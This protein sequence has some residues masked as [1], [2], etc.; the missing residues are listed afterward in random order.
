MIQAGVLLY[1]ATKDPLY[2]Q[3][4]RETAAGAY[5]YF[6]R[7][8]KTPQG[9]KLFYSNM[10]WFNVILLRGLIALYEVDKTDTYIQT[11]KENALYAWEYTRDENGL[12]GNDWTG[13]KNGKYKWLLDNACMIELYACMSEF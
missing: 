10:P 9:E 2:L 11:M 1:Q 5:G 8:R 6:T 7:V 12:L 13:E 3:D 4:A